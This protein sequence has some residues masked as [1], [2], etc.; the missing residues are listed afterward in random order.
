MIAHF[1][2]SGAESCKKRKRPAI[3]AD[4]PW[5]QAPFAEQTTLSIRIKG[6]QTDTVHAGNTVLYCG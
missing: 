5:T 2:Q 3:M 4:C 6:F 1:T